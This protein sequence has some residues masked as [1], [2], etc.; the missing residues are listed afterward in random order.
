MSFQSVTPVRLGQAA[1]TTS[2]ATFYTCP[3]KARAFLKT[4]DVCNTTAAIITADIYLVPTG[5]SAGTDTAIM[6]EVS[7][8]ANAIFQWEGVQV[9]NEADTLQCKAS[10]TGLTVTA[11]GAEAV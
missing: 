6:F 2:A 8:P 3:T 10:A 4:F 5:G 11:S 9:L 1:I 7:I